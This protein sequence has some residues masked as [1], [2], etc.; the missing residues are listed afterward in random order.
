MPPFF[1]SL[2]GVV[3]D[4]NDNLAR[5]SVDEIDSRSGDG[6]FKVGNFCGMTF[7]SMMGCNFFADLGGGGFTSSSK[8]VDLNLEL[9]VFTV[10]GRIVE[11]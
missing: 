2:G 4:S 7:L 9:N 11:S 10:F 3:G 8:P 1:S 5:L 6:L